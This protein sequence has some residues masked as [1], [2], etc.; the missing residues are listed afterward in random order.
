MKHIV[1]QLQPVRRE[2]TKI[3]QSCDRITVLDIAQSRP[4]TTGQSIEPKLYGRDHTM[5]S[6]I[7]DMTKGEY[8]SKVLT[9]LPIVGPG[10]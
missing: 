2:V 3:L 4:I 6:I 8:H 5:N 7:H 9:V 1:E 10:G